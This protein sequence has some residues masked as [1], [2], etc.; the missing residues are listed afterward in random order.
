MERSSQIDIPLHLSGSILFHVPDKMAHKTAVV[1]MCALSIVSIGLQRCSAAT[2]ISNDG[3]FDV[4]EERSM[5]SVMQNSNRGRQIT[6]NNSLT[7]SI[8]VSAEP[9][10]VNHLRFLMVKSRI[11][12]LYLINGTV[13]RFVNFQPVCTTLSTTGLAGE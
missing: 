3:M 7:P 10:R 6:S 13:C 12:P 2:Q 8:R 1:C 9:R 4:N 11:S 5:A